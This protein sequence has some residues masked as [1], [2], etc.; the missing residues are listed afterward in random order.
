MSESLILDLDR[1][2]YDNEELNRLQTEAIYAFVALKSGLS[3]REAKERFALSRSAVAALVGGEISMS[4]VVPVFYASLVGWNEYRDEHLSPDGFIEPDERL[5][6]LFETLRASGYRL[7]IGSNSTSGFVRRAAG[8]LGI[9]AEIIAP[10]LVFCMKP[11]LDFFFRAARRLSTD[12]KKCISIGDR[13]SDIDPAVAVGMKGIRVRG[14]HDVYDIE[15][16]L[17]KLKQSGQ[18]TVIL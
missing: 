18:T 10:D 3:N 5:V 12:P 9:E 7:A 4:G 11:S 17:A 16:H 2:L 1:T 8:L 13:D 15:E 14:V 6:G